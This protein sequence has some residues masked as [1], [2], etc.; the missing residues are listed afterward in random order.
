MPRI[1]CDAKFCLHNNKNIC[2]VSDLDA[3]WIDINSKGVCVDYSPVTNIE[4][5]LCTGRDRDLGGEDLES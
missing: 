1:R 5:K 4:Y 3:T 2:D